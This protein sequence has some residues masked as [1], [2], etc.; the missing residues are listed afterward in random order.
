MIRSMT[1]YGR[2]EGVW[3]GGAVAVEVRAVNH[4]FLE[5]VTRLPRSLSR[6][7][8]L[9]KKTVQRRCLRGR[10]EMNVTLAGGRNNTKTLSVDR[11]LAKHYRQALREL[12]KTLRI[13]GAI[14]LALISGFRDIL[15]VSDQPLEHDPKLSRLT[16]RLLSQAVADL[17]KMRCREGT[18]LAQDMNLRL[19]VI[20]QAKAAV[21]ERAPH[22]AHEVFVKMKAK[23]E[24]LLGAEPPDVG[25]LHQELALYV[26]RSDMTE[27]LVRLDSHM[28]QFARTLKS[29][30]S[31]G[32]TLD[33]LLQEMGRE[34]N[35]VG[36][37]ANDASVAT[38]VVQMK[39]E[40]EKI[41]EQVQNVE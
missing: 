33:F 2:R 15:T 41:R 28:V 26:E 1:G 36:S 9:L 19:G 10:V 21:L 4:R 39:A 30:E 23:V 22:V 3:Q 16:Q 17:Y 7:E 25:R 5:I 14:D 12:Q 35:T 6:S 8:D 37:K 20:R 18:A 29:D 24:K 32:K 34:I 40:L 38:L 11:S 13:G 31:V 27:E